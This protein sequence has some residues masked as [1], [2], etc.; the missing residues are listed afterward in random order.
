MPIILKDKIKP[1]AARLYPA[2]GDWSLDIDFA[3]FDVEVDGKFERFEYPFRGEAVE[4]KTDDPMVFVGQTLDFPR[5]PEDGYIDGSV[6]FHHAHNPVDITRL[7][8]AQDAGG[9]LRLAVDSTWVMSFEQSD[10]EDFDLSFEVPLTISR[11]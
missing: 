3:P 11:K 8:F 10:F 7:T 2:H 9:S 4:L 6:Y 1:V 5:N